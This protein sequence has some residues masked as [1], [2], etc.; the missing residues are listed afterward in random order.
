M[1]YVSLTVLCCWLGDRKRTVPETTRVTY[2]KDS[3]C[4]RIKLIENWL[5]EE[6]LQKMVI[7]M[8]VSTCS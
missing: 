5:T 8:S 7:K 6:Y 3:I 4:R 2:P 1:P